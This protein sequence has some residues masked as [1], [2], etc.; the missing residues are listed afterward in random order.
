MIKILDRYVIN[1]MLGPFFFGLAAFSILFFSV[2]SL[3]GV[4]RMIIDGHA[5][6]AVVAEYVWNRLPMVLVY[7]TPMAVLLAGLL[8]FG[9]LSGDS[10]LVAMKAAG[11]GF[12]RVALPGLV[13]SLAMAF[14]AAWM[15]ETIVPPTMKRAFTLLLEH[16]QP[17]ELERALM[18]TPRRLSNGQEQMV[19]AHSLNQKSKEMRGVFIHFFFKNQRRREI[20]AEVARWNGQVWLLQNLREVEFN[21]QQEPML[22]V[23]S[24]VGWTPMRFEEAPPG[25]EELS[26][27]KFRPEEMSRAEIRQALA[28]IPTPVTVADSET[29]LVRNQ[30]EVAYHQKLAIAWCCLVFGAFAIPLGVRPHRTS[31]SLG[32]G[33]SVFLILV[34]H[35]IMTLGTVMGES[36]AVSPV[37]GA[38]LPNILFGGVGAVLLVDATRR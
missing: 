20:Y 9:R 16:R 30:L 12:L 2:E 4:V 29:E 24:D 22:E 1:E 14:V 18:T 6:A 37:V 10:E 35:V 5:G 36:G 17:D 33:L 13:F 38:W 34:Y 11:I 27:R 7:T 8:T 21:S 23:R 32:L 25:P 15:N 28:E 31:T 26:R 3:M 19:Y